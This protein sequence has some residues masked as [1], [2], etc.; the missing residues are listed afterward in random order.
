MLFLAVAAISLIFSLPKFGIQAFLVGSLYWLR[1]AFYGGYFLVL[2]TLLSPKDLRV[3]FLGLGGIIM[4]TCLAQ[5]IFYP[6]VRYLQIAEW[7][8]HYFRVVGTLLDPGFVSII[9]VFC[10]IYLYTH[11]IKN[12][13]IQKISFIICYICFALTYSRTGFITIFAASAFYSWSIKSWRFISI[14][15]IILIFTLLILPRTPGG[16]GVK[17]ERT[18]SIKARIINWQNS[19]SI[20]IKNPILGVGF[21]TYRYAQKQAGFLDTSNWLKSHAGAGADSSLLFIAATTGIAGLAFF[22]RYLNSVWKISSD[23]PFIRV[24]LVALFFHSFFLN[25]LFYPFVLIWL[26]LMLSTAINP[27]ITADK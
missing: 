1:F 25:S 24:S 20:F 5:Y 19:A 21:N 6:D 4:A 14:T 22:I 16:E 13:F 3:L 18:S 26:S 9:L 8:P 10:L 15:T 2:K 12:S 27:K 7:D 17:L 11:P 23:Y